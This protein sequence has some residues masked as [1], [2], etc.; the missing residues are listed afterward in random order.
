MTEQTAASGPEAVLKRCTR[1]QEEKPL[2]AFARDRG[3]PDGRRYR[4]RACCAEIFQ[5]RKKKVD[6]R[7]AGCGTGISPYRERCQSC[8]QRGELSFRWRGGRSIDPKGYVV[9]SGYQG[10][11]NAR[12]GGQIPEH[13]LVMAQHLGRPL[14]P[15]ENVHH[16]NGDRSDN[17]IENLELWSKVQPCGQRIEDKVAWAKYILG[18][19]EPEALREQA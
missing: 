14:V 18:L 7:C 5:E 1:C 19:Y 6:K 4:C 16:K 9:L 8:K 15:G 10:H 17:R 3:S 2:D 13:I 12:V 11:P